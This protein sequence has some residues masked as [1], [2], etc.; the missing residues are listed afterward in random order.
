MFFELIGKRSQIY[1]EKEYNL[2]EVVAIF[3]KEEDAKKYIEKSRLKNPS[4]SLS[5]FRNISLLGN[6]EKA[7]VRGFAVPLN[8]PLPKIQKRKENNKNIKN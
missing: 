2:E 1:P 4:V 5:P 7:E 3:D 8:P 6:Y